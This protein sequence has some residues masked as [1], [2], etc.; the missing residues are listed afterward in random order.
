MAGHLDSLLQ[1]P[2]AHELADNKG[3][4]KQI[5]HAAA[6]LLN[7]GSPNARTFG[8]RI[9]WQ[10]NHLAP[11]DFRSCCCSLQGETGLIMLFLSLSKGPT[12]I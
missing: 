4:L 9:L 11:L 10:C 2:W 5:V 8:K 3:L 1:Q 7:E 6:G 12:S